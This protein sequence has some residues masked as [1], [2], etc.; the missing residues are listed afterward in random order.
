VTSSDGP[1]TRRGHQPP[2]LLNLSGGVDSTYAAWLLLSQGERLLIH[3]CVL[4]NH[5]RRD[6]KESQAVK[7]VLNWFSRQGFTR[8][9]YVETGFDYGNTRFII[10]DIEVIRFITGLVLRRRSLRHITTVVASGIA[11]DPVLDAAEKAR[12][13]GIMEAAAKRP[14]ELIRPIRHMSKADIIAAMPPELFA[15]TWYCRRPHN[16]GP[17]GKCR[18]CGHVRGAVDA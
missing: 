5:E 8:W 3:H 10:P 6:V 16:G 4:R 17:C 14:V 9:Q 13:H 18:T 11:E 12:I 15:L 2:L 7:A 1:D